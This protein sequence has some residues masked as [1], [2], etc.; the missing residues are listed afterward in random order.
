MG[1]S[2]SF[3]TSTKLDLIDSE[4]NEIPADLNAPTT[5]PVYRRDGKV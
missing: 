3:Q 5:I 4:V 2:A 1:A